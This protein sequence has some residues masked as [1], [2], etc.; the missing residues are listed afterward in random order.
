MRDLL[1]FL[2]I[3]GAGTWLGANITQGVVSPRLLSGDHTVAAAWARTSVRMGTVLYTPAGILILVTG[4]LLV[5][6]SDG[7]YRFEHPFVVVG[8]VVIAAG[9]FLGV[10][11]FGPQGRKSA[12]LH[13]A[14][15]SPELSSIHKR[16]A[17]FGF[18]D[19][20]LV[21]TAFLVMVTQWGA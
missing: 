8:F 3:V 17:G 11:V 20:V 7:V 9:I 1:L 13:E 2:H 5:T 15:G 18:L 14:G 10:R 4:I 16:I 6:M 19:T 21:L 12:E